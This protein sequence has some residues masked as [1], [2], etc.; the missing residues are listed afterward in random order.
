MLNDGI[1]PILLKLAKLEIPTIKYDIS[2]AIYNMTTVKEGLY[3]MKILKWDSI[4]VLFW[5]TLYDCL[6]LY[7]PIKQHCVR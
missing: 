3:T 4:D 2:R 1:M 7:D 6:D 5:L